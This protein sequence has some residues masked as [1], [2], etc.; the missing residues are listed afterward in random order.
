MPFRACN[1]FAKLHPAWH[2]ASSRPTIW[3]ALS[4]SGMRRLNLPG[5]PNK[6]TIATDG[7]APGRDAGSEL[8]TRAAAAGWK[9]SLLPAPNGRDWNDVLLARRAAA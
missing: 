4:T 2:R 6:L 1:I 9:V 3:A 8:A 5:V 7:D